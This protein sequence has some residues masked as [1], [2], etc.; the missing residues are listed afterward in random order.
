MALGVGLGMILIL[1]FGVVAV[2]STPEDYRAPVVL[3]V[4]LLIFCFVV[5]LYLHFKRQQ[6]I[7]ILNSNITKMSDDEAEWLA[8]KYQGK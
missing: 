5:L 3:L 4:I 7:D 2:S 6:D 1:L 8:E